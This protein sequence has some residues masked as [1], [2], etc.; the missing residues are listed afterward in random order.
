MLRPEKPERG[1]GSESLCPV[2]EP[3][4][5]RGMAR[6]SRRDSFLVCSGAG[7]PTGSGCAGDTRS[8]SAASVSEASPR[9][10]RL[11]RDA[12]V[13]RGVDRLLERV[14]A[15]CTFCALEARP[16]SSRAAGDVRGTCGFLRGVGRPPAAVSGS[17]A[18]KSEPELRS[19]SGQSREPWGVGPRRPARRLE[20]SPQLGSG[21]PVERCGSPSRVSGLRLPAPGAPGGDNG[22]LSLGGPAGLVP[23]V[24]LSRL[25]VL[26][27][28]TSESPD[29]ES[30]GAALASSCASRAA[31]AVS[32]SCRKSC[33]S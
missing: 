23:C 16:R 6:M 2:K 11:S 19:P 9:R 22:I 30:S 33:V 13:G 15:C 29:S 7:R 12:R 4:R 18:S 26:P 17:E 25:T 14:S 27:V 8:P 21:G 10:A 5:F 32:V 24:P 31:N 1:A 28:S 3:A 20:A